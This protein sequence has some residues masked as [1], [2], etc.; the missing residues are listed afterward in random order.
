MEAAYDA[1]L[2]ET[3]HVSTPTKPDGM[4]PAA[5]H[6][7]LDRKLRGC[8]H[9]LVFERELLSWVNGSAVPL[10]SRTCSACASVH[11]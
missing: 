6:V 9:V 4:K 2:A 10:M 7:Y 8:F 11:V 5:A 1:L 3:V